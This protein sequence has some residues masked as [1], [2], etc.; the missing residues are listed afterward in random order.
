MEIEIVKA[1]FDAEEVL[2][3]IECTFGKGERE[4]ESLQL[5]GSESSL[6]DDVV[7]IARENGVMLGTM[8]ITVP[9]DNPAI[10]GVSGV[11]T[12]EAARGKGVGGRLFSE[13]MK[14]LDSIGVEASFLGTGN[15][16]AAK[17]YD[18]NGFR[19][20]YGTGV[21]IRPRAGHETDFNRG[22]QEC[23]DGELTVSCGNQS[24]RI[25]I[26]PL[27]V[28]KSASVIY[29]INTDII[30]SSY[31]TQGSCMSLYPRYQRLEKSGGAY[32]VARDA[33]GVI[34]AVMSVK[35]VDEKNRV[36][37]FAFE[38]FSSAI[39][40]MLDTVT[41]KHKE[42]FFEAAAMDSEKARMIK[43]L[44]YTKE[45]ASVYSF[46]GFDIPTVRFYK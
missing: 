30:C 10:A 4:L 33:R 14:Y 34:G 29:D 19:Y 43:S 3:L 7:F 32:Y 12:A 6:N 5:D 37:F 20:I 41:E 17:M 26:I 38:S 25:P 28:H 44:G 35:D 16:I 13:A 39:P 45:E 27:A 42:V 8:H 2:N 46:K 9:R 15:P 24:L 21:M 31:M 23:A 40:K 11:V 1:P 36:D 18:K 22:Y